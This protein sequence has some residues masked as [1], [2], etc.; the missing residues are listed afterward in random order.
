MT[1][2][3]A[4]AIIGC[5]PS[6]VRRMIRGGRMVATAYELPN[7]R[8]FYDISEKEVRRVRASHIKETRGRPRTKN[9]GERR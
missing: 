6:H 7:G 9:L 4:S 8:L 2:N 1:P 5:D 3:E